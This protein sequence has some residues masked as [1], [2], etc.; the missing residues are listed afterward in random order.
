MAFPTALN[1]QVTDAV[2]QANLKN[3]GDA[4]AVSGGSLYQ[5]T[6]QALGNAAHNAAAGQQQMFSTALATTVQGVSTIL[7]VDTATTARAT[8]DVYS[9][10]NSNV[11]A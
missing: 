7:C 9:V 11:Y 4:P 10:N 8:L 1:S 2:V 5:A 3:L 6:S